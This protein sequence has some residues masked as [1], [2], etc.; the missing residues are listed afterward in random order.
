[1]Q[2]IAPPNRP[3]RASRRL[4]A[5]PPKTPPSLSPPPLDLN[6]PLPQLELPR[7]KK[8]RR[9]WLVVLLT[10]VG[11]LLVL[12]IAAIVWALI[13]YDGAL[14]ARDPSNHAIHEIK[15][16]YGAGTED[17]GTELEQK[18]VIKSAMAFNIYMRLSNNGIIKTG[19]YHFMASQSVPEIAQW[20]N[21]GRVG[22]RKVTIL[23]GKTVA[24]IKEGLI[25]DGFA[26]PQVE[27]AFAKK[28]EHPLLIDR[29]PGAGLEGYIFPETYHVTAD[30]D[31]EQLLIITF[32]EF[33]RRINEA[34]LRQALGARGFNLF[35]GVTLA[36]IVGLEVPTAAEQKQVA[37]IFET[38]LQRNIPLGSDPTYQYAAA[39]MGVPPAVNIDSPYNTRI[40]PGLPPGPI[41]N[42]AL[43]ALDAV[44]NPAPGD[45]LYFVAG[46]DGVTHF[47][48]TLQEHEENI[49][50]YCR[51]LCSRA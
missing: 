17:V 30:V 22:T 28:Y 51:T 4:G 49:R 20:L 2:D 18:G 13:W 7:P 38:R 1:M 8:Q 27:S 48:R 31:V 10:V 40:H 45:Y 16:M 12:A 43:S 23:P 19:T 5:T 47:S 26:R 29:P 41:A 36:S 37:Q 9:R 35:Q 34:G 11:G 46:D 33:E 15:I 21:E 32:D 6:A 42:F 3:P 39:L 24:Q 44:A 14:K 25:A 50:K